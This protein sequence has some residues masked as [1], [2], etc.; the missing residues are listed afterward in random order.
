MKCWGLHGSDGK[1]VTDAEQ[2]AKGDGYLH[3]GL[4]LR[5]RPEAS[6]SLSYE[7]HMQSERMGARLAKKDNW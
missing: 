3:G 6:P 1:P 2:T 4:A 7:R 5:L